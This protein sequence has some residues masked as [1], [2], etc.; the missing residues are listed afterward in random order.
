MSEWR[1]FQM[2]ELREAYAHV[3]TGGVAVHHTGFPFRRYRFTA[4]LFAPSTEQLLQAI[5]R[6][7]ANPKWLQYP[8]T[9]NE[10]FDLM[11]G[12]LAVAMRLCGRADYDPTQD[13]A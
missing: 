3:A 8:G 10:H 13:G 9:K 12:P 1:Y 6:T 11:G 2:M 5:R 7:G 4:H